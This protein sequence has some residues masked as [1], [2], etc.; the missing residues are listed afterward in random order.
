MTSVQLE[1]FQDSVL[2]VAGS[3]GFSPPNANADVLLAPHPVRENLAVF[4]SETSVQ[5]DPFQDSE[6][7]ILLPPSYHQDFF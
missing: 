1:P 2:A 3:P 6:L 5:A 4:K 7:S